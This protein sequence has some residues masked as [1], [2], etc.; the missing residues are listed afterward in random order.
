MALVLT[1][2]EQTK[3]SKKRRTDAALPTYF[4]ASSKADVSIS[5][6]FESFLILSS[7][8]MKTSAIDW[9]NKSLSLNKTN[10]LRD[11]LASLVATQEAGN[12]KLMV[13]AYDA[14]LQNFESFRKNFETSSRFGAVEEVNLFLS[15]LQQVLEELVLNRGRAQFDQT[16]A[17]L[18]SNN[19][20]LTG[21]S[22]ERLEEL[23][24]WNSVLSAYL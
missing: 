8:D 22:Q 21:V 20:N 17:A 24:S 19:V 11:S 6:D 14:Q 10:S 7:D 2:E 13:D 9:I 23:Q 3:V 16:M 4:S 5:R 15:D 12:A 1:A 18:S